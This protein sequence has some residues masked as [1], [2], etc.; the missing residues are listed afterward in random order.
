MTIETVTKIVHDS[1]IEELLQIALRVEDYPKILPM[2][3][4]V[5]VYDRTENSYI[6]DQV[7]GIGPVI[8]R[9][10]TVTTWTESTIS[11]Q[12][13]DRLFKVLHINWNFFQ[14]DNDVKVV[15]SLELKMNSF[16]M[17][18]IVDAFIP[19]VI[20][21]AASLFLKRLEKLDR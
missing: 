17:Q 16:S 5:N 2:W 3:K 6:T 18:K 8:K 15:V 21:S 7:V 9:F 13:I 10:R 4:S 1:T 12:S 11:V 20:N 14:Q 19:E